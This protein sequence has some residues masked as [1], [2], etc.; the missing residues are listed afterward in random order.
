[1]LEI[2][3]F[4]QLSNEVDVPRHIIHLWTKKFP[5]LSPQRSS[6]GKIGFK[7][8]D[9]A[10][11]KGLKHLLIHEKHSIHEVQ[12]MLNERGIGYVVDIGKRH[13]PAHNVFTSNTHHKSNDF[14]KTHTAKFDLNIHK[15]ITKQ[16]FSSLSTIFAKNNSKDTAN[17]STKDTLKKSDSS[18]EYR[19]LEVASDDALN[20]NLNAQ[21]DDDLAPNF[22]DNWRHLMEKTG[23]A[24]PI[25]LARDKPNIIN[26]N[27]VS[28]IWEIDDEIDLFDDEPLLHASSIPISSLKKPIHQTQPPVSSVRTV[29]EKSISSPSIGLTVEKIEQIKHLISKLDIMRDEM[30]NASNVITKTLKAFGYSGFENAYNTFDQ[31]SAYNN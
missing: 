2:I 26:D 30:T 11:A 4:E 21:N 20:A 5:I 9:V 3:S 29:T 14:D 12:A 13:N 16:T 8:R 19:P 28:D 25:E 17:N 1:M 7:N 18:P 6:D 23:K 15:N 10:L 22:E 31:K 24:T 27:L